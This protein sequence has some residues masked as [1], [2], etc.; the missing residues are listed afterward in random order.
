[1]KRIALLIIMLSTISAWAKEYDFKVDSIYYCINED[2]TSVTVTYNG[3]HHNHGNN[4]YKGYKTIPASVTYSG[5]TY[6]VT[7][8]GFDA[9]AYC[10]GLTSVTIPN[11]VTYID[12]QAFGDCSGLTSVTIPNSVT[13][14]GDRAFAD[15]KRLTSV[16]IPNSVTH[17]GDC[18]FTGC[19]GLTSLIYNAVKCQ[20]TSREFAW[21]KDCPLSKLVIGDSVTSIPNYLAY[22]KSELT[23]VI[24]PNSVTD[25]G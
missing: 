13:Y 2:D 14:I 7:A 16:T 11:S 12:D 17:I 25:I 10:S 6:S 20:Y 21:F 19:T 15:C 24:I 1:M 8:I 4:Y 23:S 22:G 3:A 9:F 18:A 5:K